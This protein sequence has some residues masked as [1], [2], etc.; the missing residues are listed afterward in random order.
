MRTDSNLV[1]DCLILPRGGCLR[2]GSALQWT[3]HWFSARESYEALRELVSDRNLARDLCYVPI[4][5]R[6]VKC[7]GND[8]AETVATYLIFQSNL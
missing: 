3:L 1:W 6:G 2:V 8:N 7:K 4:I 5:V